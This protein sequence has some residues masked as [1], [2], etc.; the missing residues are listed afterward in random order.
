MALA[1]VQTMGA[2]PEHVQPVPVKTAPTV[3]PAGK[4]SVTVS[5]LEPSVPGTLA[6]VTSVAWFTLYVRLPM[7]RPLL[8]GVRV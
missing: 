1:R 7:A 4:V 3:T 2:V 6:V 5:G 8:R